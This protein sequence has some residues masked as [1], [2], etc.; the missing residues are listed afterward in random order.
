MQSK[1]EYS[2][3][4]KTKQILIVFFY[5]VGFGS[6]ATVT[7][8]F[9]CEDI[10]GSEGKTMLYLLRKDEFKYGNYSVIVFR[11]PGNNEQFM[12]VIYTTNLFLN[13][14]LIKVCFLPIK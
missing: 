7:L 11:S 2:E 1:G 6:V 3:M 10:I 12:T 5:R 8:R 14:K 9:K 13:K 4:S